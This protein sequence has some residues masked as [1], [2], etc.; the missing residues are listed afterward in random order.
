[1]TRVSYISARINWLVFTAR[2]ASWRE[3]NEIGYYKCFG[4]VNFQPPPPTKIPP[5]SKQRTDTF[6]SVTLV[7]YWWGPRKPFAD[8]T[9]TVRYAGYIYRGIALKTCFYPPDESDSIPPC[10]LLAISTL[11]LLESPHLPPP[12]VMLARADWAH[13]CMYLPTLQVSERLTSKT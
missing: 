3:A 10:F 11:S 6:D 5:A 12:L 1:M 4:S 9:I 8:P 13:L 2:Q 7:L